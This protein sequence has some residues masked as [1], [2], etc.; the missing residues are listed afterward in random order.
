MIK[1][2]RGLLIVPA[3]LVLVLAAIAPPAAA[4]GGSNDGDNDAAMT[5]S[6]ASGSSEPLT[7]DSLRHRTNEMMEGL[8]A[9]HKNRQSDVARQRKCQ[10]AKHG[11]QTKLGN[12]QRNTAKHKALIDSIYGKVL[13]YQQRNNV[14]PANFDT[15][16]STANDAQ[17]KAGQSVSVLNDLS[18]NLD[19][20][21][22]SV[23]T[24]V[25]SFKVA[26]QQTRSDL[27]TYRKSV[28]AVLQALQS[29][30]QQ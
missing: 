25:A 4:H 11:M 20:A 23:A 15:L 9:K 12:M 2:I 27:L 19:C 3:V 29:A 5:D 14:N 17:A 18:V 16:V 8:M 24:N 6:D 21:D 1:N 13:A 10:A 22:N 30:K 26:A 28:I 7:Q